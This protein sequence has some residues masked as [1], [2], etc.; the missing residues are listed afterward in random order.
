MSSRTKTAL[1]VPVIIGVAIGVVLTGN[2]LMARPATSASADVLPPDV[3]RAYQKA[4]RSDDKPQSEKVL[5][6]KR[7]GYTPPPMPEKTSAY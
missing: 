2:Q 7:E 6:G 1:H 3:T 4:P 5:A